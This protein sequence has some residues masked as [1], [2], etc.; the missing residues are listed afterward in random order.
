M[1]TDARWLLF[2]LRSVIENPDSACLFVE[3]L[4]RVA[5]L[6]ESIGNSTPEGWKHLPTGAISAFEPPEAIGA[7][8]KPLF[9]STATT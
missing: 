2:V 9:L 8:W 5:S 3:D 7:E 4:E 6:V 1:R